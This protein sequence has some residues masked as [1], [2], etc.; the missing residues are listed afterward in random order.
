[1]ASRVEWSPEALEDV[2]AIAEY[3]ERDSKFY[4]QAV[5]AK[6]IKVSQSL[7]Q[8]PLSGRIVPEIQNDLVREKFVYSYRMIYRIES[9]RLLIVA[10]L[11]GKRLFA[12]IA[13]RFTGSNEN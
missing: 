9:E 4:A 1:M 3:I 11:H 5:V 8:F 2:D 12:S 7:A 6:I 13:E 10:V